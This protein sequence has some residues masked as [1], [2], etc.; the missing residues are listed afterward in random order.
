[1]GCCECGCTSP[2]PLLSH[3]SSPCPYRRV[4]QGWGEWVCAYYWDWRQVTCLSPPCAFTG[5]FCCLEDSKLRALSC[6]KIG[7]RSGF[8]TSVDRFKE[9]A[10]L[11]SAN[12]TGDQ[13]LFALWLKLLSGEGRAEKLQG[14][15]PPFELPSTEWLPPQRLGFFELARGAEQ[16]EKEGTWQGHK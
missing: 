3:S 6:L 7:E 13:R 14:Q 15:R 11:A 16:R 8:K 2:L 4:A 10:E 1:M 9:R 5:D 12:L